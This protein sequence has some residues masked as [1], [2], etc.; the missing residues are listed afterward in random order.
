MGL[1]RLDFLTKLDKIHGGLAYY[2][3]V[4][5]FASLGLTG[6]APPSAGLGPFTGTVTL[7]P[8][9]RPVLL[10]RNTPSFV[11][12]AEWD[13]FPVAQNAPVIIGVEEPCCHI[14]VDP[15]F[16]AFAVNTGPS[17]GGATPYEAAT[18]P[19]SGSG[20]PNTGFSS[21]AAAQ[22]FLFDEIGRYTPDDVDNAPPISNHYWVQ[23]IGAVDCTLDVPRF[24][25]F[26]YASRAFQM[27]IAEVDENRGQWHWL[28]AISKPPA[29]KAFTFTVGCLGDVDPS[30][31]IAVASGSATVYSI[32]GNRPNLAAPFPSAT[33]TPQ[34]LVSQTGGTPVGFKG[35]ANT[36]FGNSKQGTGTTL[37]SVQH[38]GT[39]RAT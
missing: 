14:T 10:A 38:D 19:N 20:P 1:V 18:N 39:I 8:N 21:F 22:T 13:T 36:T 6:Y 32:K 2:V 17:V 12:T 29:G 33:A 35:T 37:F 26:R 30:S 28:F 34:L 15:Y 23:G 9:R 27:S 31:G 5:G 16:A 4:D 24:G 11:N 3:L 25:C 7:N